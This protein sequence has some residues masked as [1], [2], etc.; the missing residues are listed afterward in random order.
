MIHAEVAERLVEAHAV[1]ALRR[2]GHHREAG[3]CPR[4]TSADS[5]MT[6]PIE[7]PWPPMN[8]VAEC[9]TMSA[10]CSIGRQ[11]YGRGE[12]VV[13]DERDAAPRARCAATR[14]M[15]STLITGLPMVSAKTALVFGR[16]RPAEV[17][18]IVGIDE[19]RLDA[20]PAE[21]HVELRIGAAVERRGGDQLVPGLEQGQQ[22]HH[23]RRHVRK[24][25]PTHP[26]RPRE[27]PCAPRRPRWSG[28]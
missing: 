3:R 5:T 24:R 22:R 28:S 4:E 20:E 6:P 2:L 11:S 19:L 10:P 13:D 12:G 18:G 14:S 21:A 15:S 8:L 1:I 26:V 25:A 23:L 9:T 16:D 27:R 17:L 7:V